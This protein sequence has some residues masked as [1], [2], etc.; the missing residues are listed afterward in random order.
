MVG[1]AAADDTAA[2]DHNLR[3]IFH[4]KNCSQFFSQSIPE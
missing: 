3:A 4:L 1:G 2:D